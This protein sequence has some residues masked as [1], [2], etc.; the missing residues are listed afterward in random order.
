M[1]LP[2][3]L[4]DY[5][6]FNSW[7]NKRILNWLFSKPLELLDREIPSSFPSLRKTMLHIW[8]AE[9]IWMHRLQGKVA[10]SFPSETFTGTADDL[11]KGLLATSEHFAAFL[12]N[13]PDQFFQQEIRYQNSRGEQ[14][15]T[16]N[17]EVILHCIQHSTFHRGQL[18]TMARNLGLID[19]PQTDYIGYVRERT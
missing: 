1:N 12:H 4:K 5:G 16:P 13:C 19:P 14:F 10:T 2:A 6:H 11:K 9:Q 18:V 15:T 3:L 8:D 17:S 7:A